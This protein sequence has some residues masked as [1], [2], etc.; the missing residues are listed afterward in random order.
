[1]KVEVIKVNDNTYQVEVTKKKSI[2][3]QANNKEEAVKKA[4]KKSRNFFG[5]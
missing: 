3:L 5:I 2:V 1:M 4:M